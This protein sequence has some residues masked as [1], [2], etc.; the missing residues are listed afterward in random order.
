[1]KKAVLVVGLVV[2]CAGLGFGQALVTVTNSSLEKFQQQ[3]LAAERDYRENYA[4]LGFPSPEELERQRV[5]DLD[6]RMI[7]ADQLRQ[8]RL[9]Q[10]RLAL[11]ERR[12]DL[13]VARL[14]AEIEAR[15]YEREANA[16]YNSGYYGGYYGNN[17]GYGGYGN[18]GY[19]DPF[20]RRRYRGGRGYW[21]QN[22][23]L[24][25]INLGGY[26]AMP[27]GV[28]PAPSSQPFFRGSITTRKHR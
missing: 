10:E 26:R 20:G 9:E 5:E 27:Y 8:A 24:P 16:S 11:D 2:S 23:L 28:L 12:L 21:D 25:L 19:Y 18:Y 22:R 17:A 7:I 15:E 4:K 14:D 6:A 1:M 3:R 13:E